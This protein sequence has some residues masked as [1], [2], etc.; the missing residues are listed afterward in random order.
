M[1]LYQIIMTDAALAYTKSLLMKRT[2]KD[3][4]ELSILRNSRQ[5][6]FNA[7]ELK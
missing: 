6:L 5:A 3:K 7:M 1:T 4:K 2:G